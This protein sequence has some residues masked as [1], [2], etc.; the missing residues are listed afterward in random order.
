MARISFT[1]HL[2][3]FM[4]VPSL[5]V[6]AADLASALDLVFEVHPKLRS[7]ILDDQGCLRRH[8]AIFVDGTLVRD[9]VSLSTHL[10]PE[11]EVFVM[12]A[13]SGG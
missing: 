1:N 2:D 10:Q 5:H 8:V 4:D 11:S 13:L 6:K 12:Q 3:R 9:R 7:Y